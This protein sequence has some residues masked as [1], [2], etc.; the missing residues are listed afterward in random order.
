MLSL[1]AFDSSGLCLVPCLL[2]PDKTK[3]LSVAVCMFCLE[4]AFMHLSCHQSPWGLYRRWV[5]CHS[6][7]VLFLSLV[8]DWQFGVVK[9]FLF[10]VSSILHKQSWCSIIVLPL[11]I[12]SFSCIFIPGRPPSVW[13][14]VL[15]N[16][17]GS[18]WLPKDNLK[19]QHLQN[20][21]VKVQ[22][23]KHSVSRRICQNP[24]SVSYLLKNLAFVILASI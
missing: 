10:A 17:S 6:F 21:D 11:S 19:K 5:R 2:I 4:Y 23:L 3:K 9:F 13:V 24:F 15:Q 12:M 7:H 16:A 8:W 20:G 18:K 22:I 1:L 14:M